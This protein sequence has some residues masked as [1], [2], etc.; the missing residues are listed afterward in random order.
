MRSVAITAALIVSVFVASGSCTLSARSSATAASFYK[1]W[2]KSIPASLTAAALT[3]DGQLIFGGN[4][5]NLYSQSAVDGSPIWSVPCNSAILNQP[6]VADGRVFFAT[7]DGNF[8]A[9]SAKNGTVL[10]KVNLIAP[11]EANAFTRVAY[12]AA[13]GRVLV[14]AP[15]SQTMYCVNLQYNNVSWSADGSSEPVTP[16]DGTAWVT[17]SGY[18]F[19]YNVT[20]GMQ[21]ISANIGGD[22]L[23]R[24][25]VRRDTVFATSSGGF[26]TIDAKQNSL[27]WLLTTETS[28]YSNCVSATGNEQDDGFIAFGTDRGSVVVVAPF[29]QSTQWEYNMTNSAPIWTTPSVAGDVII[30]ISA[31]GD[32]IALNATT[33]TLIAT[34]NLTAGTA[35]V[36]AVTILASSATDAAPTIT[37]FATTLTGEVVAL[38]LSGVPPPTLSPPTATVAPSTTSAA[39]TITQLRCLADN[40]TSCQQAIIAPGCVAQGSGSLQRACTSDGAAMKVTWYSAADCNASTGSSSTVVY[41]TN[42]CYTDVAGSFEVLQCAP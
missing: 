17:F 25:L 7:Y 14:S 12:D 8:Y 9:V 11:S 41:A 29:V 10:N 39:A 24:P 32:V 36:S 30:A 34:Y 18:V 2:K 21:M 16:G 37:V 35:K 33:G 19:Q 5:G 22:Q 28:T 1:V 3:D 6:L 26:F 27:Q 20:S 13:S 31:Y 38:T 4:D 23:N 40:C 15:S 42:T